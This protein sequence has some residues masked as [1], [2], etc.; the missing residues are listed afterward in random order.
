MNTILID[1]TDDEETQNAF[2]NVAEG[3]TVEM[4]IQVLVSEK[5]SDRIAGTI[6][7]PVDQVRRQTSDTEAV[8]RQSE[9]NELDQPDYDQDGPD[10]KVPGGAL[11][12]MVN[13]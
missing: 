13:G 12:S 11:R 5:S 4:T 3:Q 9:A 7:L 2:A 6:R 8:D 1:T 10:S